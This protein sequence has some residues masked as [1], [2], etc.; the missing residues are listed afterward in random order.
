METFGVRLKQILNSRGITQK[1]FADM[2]GKEDTYISKVC[3]DKYNVSL[4]TVLQ[5]AEALGVSPAIFFSEPDDADKE[6]ISG[7]VKDWPDD[8][9]DFIKAQK[10]GPW[11]YLAKDLSSEN[12]T[13]DQIVKVVQL[14]KET[15]EKTK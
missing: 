12:L 5:F 10:N 2:V 6:L 15:V 9:I 4:D 8:L 7:L 11:I 13:P 14:W 1:Q 3:N